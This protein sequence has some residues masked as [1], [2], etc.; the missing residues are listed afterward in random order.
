MQPGRRPSRL[1][2]RR[3]ASHGSHLRVTVL[4]S[5]CGSIRYFVLAMDTP[6]HPRGIFRPSSA[7]LPPMKEGAGKT[8]CR[9]GTHGPLCGRWQQELHSGIQ[10]KPSNRPSLRS[11]VTAYVVLSPGSDALLP[12]SSR[13]MA[14]ARAGR[15]ATSPLG[16]D[17]QTPGVRTTRFCRTLMAPVVCARSS[18]TVSRPARPFAPT[19]PAST[20][21]RPAFVTIAIRPS[22]LGRVAAMDT[23]LPNFGKV[24]YFRRCAL[25]ER[26]G[27]LPVEERKVS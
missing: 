9:P 22:S 24:E 5:A 8:G 6:S 21:A 20:A 18:L 19:P 12:P 11:G 26:L 10:V 13:E 27:V 4:D 17:A 7:W 16:L 15:A 1:S 23:P 3:V 2:T 25:T 14:D